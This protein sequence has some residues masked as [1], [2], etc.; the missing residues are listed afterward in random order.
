LYL[1]VFSA[2]LF[3]GRNFVPIT[4]ATGLL[5]AFFHKRA[6]HN[7]REIEMEKLVEEARLIGVSLDEK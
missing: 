4:A 7:A 2:L 3:L 1:F 6:H 5:L